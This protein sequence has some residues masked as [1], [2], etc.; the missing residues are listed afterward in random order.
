ME[1]RQYYRTASKPNIKLAE[2]QYRDIKRINKDILGDMSMKDFKRA[3]HSPYTSPEIRAHLTYTLFSEKPID[4]KYFISLGNKKQLSMQETLVI[5]ITGKDELTKLEYTYLS[6]KTRKME[7]YVLSNKQKEHILSWY[8]PAG[9]SKPE[10][11]K[12]LATGRVASANAAKLAYNMKKFTTALVDLIYTFNTLN[13]PEHFIYE[14][15]G[16]EISVDM[17]S[18]TEEETMPSQRQE[19]AMMYKRDLEHM[20][21]ELIKYRDQLNKLGIDTLEVQSKFNELFSAIHTFI[22]NDKLNEPITS[23]DIHDEYT[24]QLYSIAIPGESLA[25]AA[26]DMMQHV[27]EIDITE[28]GIDKKGGLQTVEDFVDYSRSKVEKREKGIDTGKYKEFIQRRMGLLKSGSE[29][30]S[31]FMVSDSSNATKEKD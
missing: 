21:W 11:L 8:P 25:R 24:R 3:F 2:Y 18:N 28:P 7:P 10:L 27:E 16:E 26:V 17:R 31:S 22:T 12:A 1:F 5:D 14:D 15:S 13:D 30:A 23:I 9:K 6:K 4:I 20:Q 29:K 19:Y